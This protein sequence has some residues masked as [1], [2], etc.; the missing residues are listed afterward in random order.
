[1]GPSVYKVTKWLNLGYVANNFTVE[2][3]YSFEQNV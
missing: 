2:L 1:V 3:T